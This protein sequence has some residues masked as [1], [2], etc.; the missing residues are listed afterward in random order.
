MDDIEFCHP[1]LEQNGKLETVR[2]LG[3]VQ[4]KAKLLFYAFLYPVESLN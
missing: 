1:C 3:R 2:H 4:S